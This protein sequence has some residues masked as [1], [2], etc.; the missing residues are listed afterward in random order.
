MNFAILLLGL[1]ACEE[2]ETG[3]APDL[4]NTT[5]NTDSCGGTS[6]VIVSLECQ[7]TGVQDHPDYGPLP[8]FSIRANVTDEDG[9]ITYYQMFVDYDA[10]LDQDKDDNAESLRPAEGS[11]SNEQ[12]G[13]DEANIGVTIYLNGSTPDYDTTYEWF[14]QI[15]DALG[16]ISE[17]MMIQ[18]TTPNSEGEGE[19]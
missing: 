17:P 19:P 12:C 7:N 13:I 11:L 10:N 8:T 2:K 4:V 6:P 18:C 15:S 3:T 14:V 9:D 1:W 5:T 16:K